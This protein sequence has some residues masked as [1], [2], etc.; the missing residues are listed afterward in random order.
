MQSRILLPIWAIIA[1]ANKKAQ[2]RYLIWAL[3]CT[4]KIFLGSSEN[5]DLHI[6]KWRRYFNSVQVAVQQETSVDIAFFD[7]FGTSHEITA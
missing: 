7:S 5:M 3:I 2:M 4:G 1:E 6:L